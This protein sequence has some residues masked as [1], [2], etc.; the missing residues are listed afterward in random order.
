MPSDRGFLDES[1]T[2]WIKIHLCGVAH[3]PPGIEFDAIID[4]G[5]SGFLSVPMQVA[6]S[7]KLPLD[8][9]VNVEQALGETVTHLQTL[10]RMMLAGKTET[11]PVILASNSENVLVGTQVLRL[12]RLGLLILK[13]NVLLI[14]EDEHGLD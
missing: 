14:D 9:A 13:G 2:P 11:V 10:A 6:F 12:F 1:G 8:G 7:L 3:D 5:F 4:T